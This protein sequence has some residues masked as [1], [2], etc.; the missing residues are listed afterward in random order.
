MPWLR[1]RFSLSRT[2]SMLF[3]PFLFFSFF[4]SCNLDP[5]FVN[6]GDQQWICTDCA[7][8]QWRMLGN[9]TGVISCFPPEQSSCEI[10]NSGYTSEF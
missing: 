2:S 8:S 1:N 3:F 6:L 9:C 10:S 7:A 5:L 4:W